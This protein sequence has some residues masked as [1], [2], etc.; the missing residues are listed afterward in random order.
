MNTPLKKIDSEAEY[1]ERH[2][3]FMKEKQDIFR[4]GFKYIGNP[5]AFVL[6]YDTLLLEAEFINLFPASYCQEQRERLYS[7]LNKPDA[8]RDWISEHRKLFK[9]S[10]KEVVRHAKDKKVRD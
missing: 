1:W 4:K 7:I 5:R 9:K 8:V 2:K 6:K 3:E 10:V